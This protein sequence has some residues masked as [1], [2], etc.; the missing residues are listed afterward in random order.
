MVPR[1]S[2]INNSHLSSTSLFL[3]I[4]PSLPTSSKIK[5][6]IKWNKRKDGRSQMI[7]RVAQ[8]TLSTNSR[9]ERKKEEER[10]RRNIHEITH[11]EVCHAFRWT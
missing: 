3:A 8:A 5:I 11:I 6:R 2:I 7:P 9:L 4:N 1:P 10:R